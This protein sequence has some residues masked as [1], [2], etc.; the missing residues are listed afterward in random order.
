MK[1]RKVLGIAMAVLLATML[2]GSAGIAVAAPAADAPVA[3][4]PG[5]GAR[6]GAAIHD[7]GA[8]AIDIVADLT[9]LDTDAIFDR[10][11][12]GESIAA[13]AESEG[14]GTD[15]LVT[16]MLDVRATILSDKVADGSITQDQ[17]DVMLTNMED[18][19]AERVTS[20]EL[21]RP[22]DRGFGGGMG[23]GAGGGQGMGGNGGECVYTN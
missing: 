20:E 3:D 8:R 5:F 13:I 1:T 10:R 12:D 6:I 16:E 23:Y 7:A 2:L 17:A 21:G 19:V 18:R 11:S 9:G 14:V 4:R 15:T 22:A